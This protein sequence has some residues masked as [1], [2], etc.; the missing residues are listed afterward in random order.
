MDWD[1]ILL[2]IVKGFATALVAVIMGYVGVAIKKLFAWFS[3]KLNDSTLKRVVSNIEKTIEECVNATE[4]TIVKTA[5]NIGS[6][7]EA[8]K[9]E[10]FKYALNSVITTTNE[11]AKAMVTSA[12]GDLNVWLTNKIETYVKSISGNS[13]LGF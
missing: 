11:K 12:Y 7:D 6:W 13:K 10:A 4:Q 8:K 5:K 9:G 2:M 3:G 1:A